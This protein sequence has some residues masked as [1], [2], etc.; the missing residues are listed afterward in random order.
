VSGEAGLTVSPEPASAPPGYPREYERRLTLRDGRTVFVRPVVPQDAA[1][2]ADA[3]RSADPETLRWRFL[4]APPHL[5]PALL[6]EL[7]VLDYRRRFALVAAEEQTCHGVAIARYV[8]AADGLADVAVAV[9]P[10]WRRVGLATALIEL[11]ARAALDRGIREFSALYLAENRPVAALLRHAV[12]S[13][14]QLI[15][16]GFAEV[17]VALEREQIETAVKTLD[18]AP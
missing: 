10:G 18:E 16:A 6:A 3:I 5:T 17:V 9:D 4:G 13:G 14:R 11:L 8:E 2:L 12:P 7:T 1:Q 15:H